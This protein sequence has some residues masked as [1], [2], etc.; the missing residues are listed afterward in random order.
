MWSTDAT[1]DEGGFNTTITQSPAVG[2]GGES[3]QMTV[4]PVAIRQLLEN[5]DENKNVHVVVVGIIKQVG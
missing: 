2:A 4:I 1:Q 5:N 3:K